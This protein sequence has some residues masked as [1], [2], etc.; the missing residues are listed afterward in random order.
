MHSAGE[1]NRGTGKVRYGCGD[2]SK[3]IHLTDKYMLLERDML[4]RDP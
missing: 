1:I 2:A 4:C 3:D